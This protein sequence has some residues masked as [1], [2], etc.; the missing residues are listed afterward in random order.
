MLTHTIESTIDNALEGRVN[1]ILENSFHLTL[2]ASGG[3]RFAEAA[4][5]V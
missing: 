3:V 2:A 5:F 4:T 1:C